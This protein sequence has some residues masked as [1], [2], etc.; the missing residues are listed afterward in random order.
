MQPCTLIPNYHFENPVFRKCGSIRWF[1]FICD[2]FLACVYTF[3][4]LMVYNSKIRFEI[5]NKRVDK[6]II[7]QRLVVV[8]L[9]LPVR[10]PARYLDNE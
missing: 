5:S 8:P 10:Y 7:F 2:F 9:S 6:S 4:Y 1:V 3:I